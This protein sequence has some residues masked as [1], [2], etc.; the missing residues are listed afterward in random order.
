MLSSQIFFWVLS[1]ISIMACAS[2]VFSFSSSKSHCSKSSSIADSIVHNSWSH[3]SVLYN[4]NTKREF[5]SI[6]PSKYQGIG[7]TCVCTSVW[8][9]ARIHIRRKEI[10]TWLDEVSSAK[11]TFLEVFFFVLVNDACAVLDEWLSVVSF[12]MGKCK[13]IFIWLND[14]G[15][16]DVK[17][18]KEKEER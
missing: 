10:H 11:R 4:S 15:I 2:S 17:S 12:V 18:T 5:R 3:C 14:V 16:Y 8:R 1:I 9:N 7:Y 13:T 6:I